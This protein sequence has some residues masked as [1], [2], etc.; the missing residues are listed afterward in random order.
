MLAYTGLRRSRG[1]GRDPGRDG[2]GFF[3][4]PF[5]IFVIPWDGTGRDGTGRGDGPEK[6]PLIF[7]ILCKYIDKVYTIPRSKET[8]SV[9]FPSSVPKVRTELVL[10]TDQT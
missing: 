8:D 3:K 4:N 5:R 2:T 7:F 10:S 9:H 6:C 1:T